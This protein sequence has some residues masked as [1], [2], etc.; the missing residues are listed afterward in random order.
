MS[1]GEKRFKVYNKTIFR[2]GDSEHLNM[3]TK[4]DL[5]KLIAAHQSGMAEPDSGSDTA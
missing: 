3:C 2:R 1:C 5:D 4:I